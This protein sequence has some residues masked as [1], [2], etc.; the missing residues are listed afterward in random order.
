MNL[1]NND[2][3]K[4]LDIR[5]LV[6]FFAS[7][8]VDYF[9][10]FFFCIILFGHYFLNDCED[11]LGM[12]LTI[13]VLFARSKIDDFDF[14]LSIFVFNLIFFASYFVCQL[15]DFTPNGTSFSDFDWILFLFV[16]K[17]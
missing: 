10:C 7:S 5:V 13:F 9:I 15:F 12:K 2:S 14:E 11:E 6:F 16:S 1:H 4:W 8:S 17:V 3:V